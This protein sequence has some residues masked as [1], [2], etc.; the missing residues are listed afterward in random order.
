LNTVIGHLGSLST[1][2]NALNNTSFPMWNSVANAYENATG[3]P[4][5]KDFDTT[6]KAVV[7]ELTRVWR[8]TGGS[9]GDIKTWSDQI[10]AANSPDQLHSVIGKIGE[11]LESKI[12]SLA[13]TY[14]QGMGTTADPIE[15]VTPKSRQTLD[16]LMG[17]AAPPSIDGWTDAGG[18]VKIR[19]QQ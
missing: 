7:D 1:A 2:A 18:G 14:K 17:N 12:N 13:E 6:K 9:E 11:L 19:R 10:N 5:V 15:F 4:R 8:G 3:D 16:T